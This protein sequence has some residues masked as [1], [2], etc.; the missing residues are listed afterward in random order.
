[1]LNVIW[2]LVYTITVLISRFSFFL[3]VW[4]QC[5]FNGNHYPSIRFKLRPIIV[6]FVT[7][8]T[9]WFKMYNHCCMYL[10]HQPWIKTMI[11]P[12]PIISVFYIVRISFYAQTR[13]VHIYFDTSQKPKNAPKKKIVTLCTYLVGY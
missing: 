13:Y 9:I 2:N 7:C 5:Q 12:P 8:A 11:K 1:M 6:L 10:T 4:F 3:C